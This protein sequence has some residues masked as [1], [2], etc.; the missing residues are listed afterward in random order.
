MQADLP[1]LPEHDKLA[2]AMITAP[3]A[4]LLTGKDLLVCQRKDTIDRVLAAFQQK[5]KDCVLVYEDKHL[6]GIISNRDLLLKVA[7]KVSDLS[8][9]TA[10]M[11]MTPRPDFLDAD[12]PLAFAVN[13][14][15]I[16]GFRHLPVIADDGTPLSIISIR[17]VLAYLTRQSAAWLRP[18]ER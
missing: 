1:Q 18:S 15:A 16:G 8:K 12:A 2:Q 7:G 10:E 14:M 13:K 4:E 6:V 9:V 5:K 11:V 3:V 17:D